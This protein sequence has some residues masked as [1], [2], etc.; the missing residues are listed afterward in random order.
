VKLMTAAASPRVSGHKRKWEHE[1]GH[2]PAS[3]QKPMS[4]GTHDGKLLPLHQQ[5][6]LST[7]LGH[8]NLPSTKKC[9][10]EGKCKRNHDVAAFTA[11]NCWIT[12]KAT[13]H[14]ELIK[15]LEDKYGKK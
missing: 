9:L 4:R 3:L 11:E 13:K 8:F 15:Y 7:V 1:K 12:A 6:C 10:G 5:L 2:G 14:A